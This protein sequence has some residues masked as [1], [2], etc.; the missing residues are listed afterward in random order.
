MGPGFFPTILSWLLILLGAAIGAARALPSGEPASPIAWRPV[1]LITAAVIVF[2]LLIDRAGLVAATAGVVSVGACAGR[3]VRPLEVVL[4]AGVM[5][6]SAAGLF[7]YALGLP[8]P[9]WG[10]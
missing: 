10:R 6:I 4:L 9:L 2:S 7:V 1:I 3:D 8:L 5:A